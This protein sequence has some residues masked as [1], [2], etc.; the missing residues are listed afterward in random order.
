MREQ[1]SDDIQCRLRIAIVGQAKIRMKPAARALLERFGHEG[2]IQAEIRGNVLHDRAQ[3]KSVIGGRER[4]VVRYV[5]LVLARAMLVM[6]RRDRNAHR[7][8]RRDHCVA[9]F[10]ASGSK[11]QKP[12]Y[13]P[14]SA[15][16][17]EGSPAA[18][19][20]KR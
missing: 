17:V 12:K 3:R 10:L 13:E 5:D 19:R 15:V 9:G 8:Q 16:V 11:P 2:C 6:G 14:T 7:A 4:I 20:S 18:V 1:S